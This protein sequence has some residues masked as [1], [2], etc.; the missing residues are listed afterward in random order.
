MVVFTLSIHRRPAM[1]YPALPPTDLEYILSH[2][3]AL[4]RELKGERLFITGGSGF[5]GV[6]LLEALSHARQR[7][8]LDLRATVLARDAAATALRLPHL[9]RRKE[10]EWLEGDVRDFC[11][12][13]GAYAQVLHLATPASAVLNADQPEA[14]FDIIVAGTQHVLAF[15]QQAGA[16]NLLLA[17]SGAIYGPQPPGL[18]AIPESYGGAPNPS[19]PASAYAEGKRAAE[20]LCACAYRRGQPAPKIARC[21]AFVG[22]RLPLGAHFA[23]GNFIRDALEADEISVQGD[24]SPYRSY[25]YAAD[26]IIWLL[27]ILLR[28]EAN[29][30]Y[31]V[32][33]EQ[34]I[35][36]AELARRVGA[37]LAPEKRIAIR[38]PPSGQP[39]SRYV[40]DIARARSELGLQ[41]GVSLEQGIERTAS[42]HASC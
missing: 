36:I 40:P 15:A 20:L 10:F 8:Q 26:L 29:R 19:D 13:Q 34:A 11:F 2:T 4:W 5:F 17:S 38:Q 39:P 6:W 12:P 41:I 7:L 42:W 25:L 22:P 33:A 24:G 1:S 30:P 14:M 21:F 37:L 16:A 3:E 28:G 31:N 23:I 18:E 35:S 27:A 9:A 32:G